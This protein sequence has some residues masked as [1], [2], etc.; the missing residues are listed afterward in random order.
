MLCVPFLK[1]KTATKLASNIFLLRPGIELIIRERLQAQAT[2]ST[3]LSDVQKI[4]NHTSSPSSVISDLD[5]ETLKSTVIALADKNQLTGNDILKIFNGFTTIQVETVT[6]L[7]KL[8]KSSIKQLDLAMREIDDAKIKINWVPTP[9][10][11]GPETGPTGAT[12]NRIGVNNSNSDIDLKI[13]ELRIKK[14]NSERQ[15]SERKDLG[16]FASPFSSNLIGEKSISYDTQLQE[17][18][19]KRDKIADNAFRAMR[20]IEIITGEIS[21]LGLIDIL[22]IYT[23]LWAIDIKSLIGFL[24]ED[25]FQRLIDYNPELKSSAIQAKGTD[26][27]SSLTDFENKLINVLSFADKLLIQQ[28]GSPLEELGGVI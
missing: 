14:L 23:A 13:T 6:R 2:D 21:G 17:Q 25:S 15:I 5:D 22:S 8:I 20:V 19:Q 7:I 16:D 3:F 10:I 27:I 18:I 11:E 28:Q 24:D 12:L 9:S 1:D 26:I 4:I